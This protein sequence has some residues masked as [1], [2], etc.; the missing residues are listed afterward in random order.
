M[1]VGRFSGGSH[2]FVVDH[3]TP[4]AMERGAI[5]I[6]QNGD[7]I[8]LDADSDEITLDVADAEIQKRLGYGERL[9]HM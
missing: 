4:R 1:T 9:N 3:I 7:A 2:G 5:V 8:I 6:I